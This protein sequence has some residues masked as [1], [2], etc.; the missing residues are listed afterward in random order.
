MRGYSDRINHALAFAAKHHDTQVR[1]GLRMPY[2]THAANVAVIL[3]HYRCDESV[4]VAGVLHDAIEDSV[5]DGLTRTDLSDRI[6]SKF[7][8]DV[9]T[10]VLSVTRR[11]VDDDGIEMSKDDVRDDYLLRLASASEPARVVCAA[12]TLHNAGTILADLRR[13]IEPATVWG[14]GGSGREGTLQWYRAVADRLRAVGF[15]APIMDEL[16]TMVAALEVAPAGDAP[17]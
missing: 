17:A 14:R 5:R 4:V 3:T 1:K 12:H 10:V 2:V 11:R 6:G 16:S 8:E 13:T 9:L 7:G 15:S